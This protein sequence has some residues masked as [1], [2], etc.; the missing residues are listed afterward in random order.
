MPTY[1]INDPT[2]LEAELT[3]ALIRQMEEESRE[4]AER[5]KT[6]LT[7]LFERTFA[8]WDKLPYRGATKFGKPSVKIDYDLTSS[9]SGVQITLRCQVIDEGRGAHQLWHWLSFG[10]PDWTAT[11]TIRFKTRTGVR[12][13]PR[14]LDAQPFPGWSGNWVS[15]KKG[16]VRKGIEPREW[17]ETIAE[18]LQKHIRGSAEYEQFEYEREEITR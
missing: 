16:R 4:V 2:S 6:F 14:D 18:E 3:R 1:L 10:T 5:A 12:T 8:H 13:S 17:Y 11:K 7:S 9:A 15:I